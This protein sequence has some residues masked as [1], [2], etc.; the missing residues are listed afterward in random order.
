MCFFHADAIIASMKYYE[1]ALTQSRNSA[2]TV[3]T[4]SSDNTYAIGA[5]VKVTL[6][7]KSD[8]GVVVRQV[9][10]PQFKTKLISGDLD[11][12]SI[13]VQL[14][15]LAGWISE[16]YRT[17][18]G[19]VFKMMVPRGAETSR[20]TGAK[21]TKTN[22]ISRHSSA[23]ELTVDQKQALRKINANPNTSLL[24]GV[25]G[26]GKTRLY[27]EL[28]KKAR[29][30]G[31]ASIV[32]VPEISLTSQIV[33]DFENELG[34]VFVT[35]STMTESERHKTWLKINKSKAPIVIGPRSALFSPI[36]NLGLII[37]DECHDN[38]YKQDSSPRYNTLKVAR[39]LAD[40]HKAKL[41]LGSATPSITDYYLASSK[42]RIVHL[43]NSITSHS[44]RTVSI[45][46]MRGSKGQIFSAEFL[47]QLAQTLER[48]EQALIYHNRRGTAPIV[49]CNKCGWVAKCP[50]CHI[51]VVLHLDKH[52][53]RCH[54]CSYNQKLPTSCPDCTNT[55]IIFKGIGT[56]KLVSE[57]ERLFPKTTVAR[58]DTDNK[59]SDTVASRYQE[60]Y[61][62]SIDIIVG[63]QMIAK[64]LDLPKLSFGGIVSADT[65][66]S[67]PDYSSNEKVFQLLHQVIG[68]VGR[69]TKSS[70]V[71]I[72]TMSPDNPVI[73]L[74]SR[75]DYEGYYAWAIKQRK[76]GQ[77]PPYTHLLLLTCSYASKESARKAAEKARN[78]IENLKINDIR[79]SGPV[80][81]FYERQGTKYR[82]QLLVRAKSR[83]NLVKVARLFESNNKW[84]I[85]LDPSSL[86]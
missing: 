24:Y 30:A 7:G 79:I 54:T 43:A 36:I 15:K 65:G 64:G 8:V 72:Q 55:D 70:Y 83:R 69:H 77:Y 71:G 31:L 3:L 66:L 33:A 40:Y 49:L 14:I 85:D 75:Q 21:I 44:S 6:R 63:T 12:L 76:L 45:I 46:D 19:A 57:L 50:R 5:L 4:Y 74:A 68:R 32:L 1:V 84:T 56:K 2:H 67:I 39:K 26:S 41:V 62:G 86:L 18:L 23:H 42:S 20:R 27:I 34:G 35:H 37:I 51:P 60:I 61:D 11:G 29:R 48:G 25:T 10:R 78:Q 80:A 13:P 16:Y 22:E 17:P 59:K 81:S 52:S 38:A 28:A 73:E 82:W 9:P 58:F 53:L 47:E